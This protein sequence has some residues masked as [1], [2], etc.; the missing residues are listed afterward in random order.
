M[1]QYF[2]ELY[3]EKYF[4]NEFVYHFP[5]NDDAYVVIRDG[6]YFLTGPLFEKCTSFD[7]FL[8]LARMAMDEMHATLWAMRAI[9]LRPQIGNPFRIEDDGTIV[10]GL[11]PGEGGGHVM[12]DVR[13]LPEDTTT[14][15]TPTRAQSLRQKLAADRHLTFAI[16]L[17]TLNNAQ[18]SHL[19]RCLEEIEAFLRQK[20]S[21]ARLCSEAERERFTRTANTAES[22]GLDSRHRSG[23]F[24]PPVNPM[25]FREA[26]DF[27]TKLCRNAIAYR[28]DSKH[29]GG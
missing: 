4:L 12:P 29:Q 27:M 2:I 17:V 13:V 21:A 14:I 15:P 11:N 24:D 18:W 16:T 10:G 19:Y 5:S 25:S 1:P 9:T 3:A 7:E 20:V 26:R 28:E 6:E 8:P 23:K 22:A